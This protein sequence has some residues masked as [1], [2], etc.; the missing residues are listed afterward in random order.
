MGAEGHENDASIFGRSALSKRMEAGSLNVPPPADV[1][2]VKLP[3]VILGDAIF[4]LR[5]WLMKPFS[6]NNQTFEKRV[7]DYRLSRARRCIENAF[8]VMAAR[9]RILCTTIKAGLDTVDAIVK[10]CVVLHNYMIQ[11]ENAH[12]IPSGFIDSECSG[13]FKAGEWRSVTKDDDGLRRLNRQG[14]PNY[15]Y[16]AKDVRDFFCDYFNSAEGSVPW[17]NDIVENCGRVISEY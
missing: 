1:C 8:G 10:A 16:S 15:S 12:Y 9:W 11:T 17:Q 2:G 7:Y 13:H 3:H 14:S 5:S 6:E 4:P